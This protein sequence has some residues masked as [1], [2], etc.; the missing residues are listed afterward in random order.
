MR[1][2]SRDELLEAAEGRVPRPD[3][4]ARCAGCR[5]EVESLAAVL[6]G[7]AS[8]DVPEPSPLF[9]DLFS[10][11]VS[12]AVRREDV[13]ADAVPRRRAL[14]AAWR[15]RVAAPVAAGLVV[16]AAV[17]VG[18]LD[19]P[20]RSTTP[21][22]PRVASAAGASTSTAAPPIEEASGSDDE[23]WGVFTSLAAEVDP[24][25]SGMALPAP[26]GA[27]RALLQL[28][29]AERGELVRLLQAELA[30]RGVRTEG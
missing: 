13:A 12:E 17:A 29:D 25:D 14:R 7:A 4:V 15:W 27:D 26:G 28:S 2:L 24:G 21:A 8:V 18:L 1:H 5:G 22:S 19:R 20:V 10:A 16:I 3:H 30:Q 6:R 23:W 9:W 11:R